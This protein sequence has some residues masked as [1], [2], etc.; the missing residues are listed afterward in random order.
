[1]PSLFRRPKSRFL[2]VP[3]WLT[4]SRF[5]CA[6]RHV[7]SALHGTTVWA[8]GVLSYELVHGRPPF[9]GGTREETER[10]I[11]EQEVAVAPQVGT[12]LCRH[13]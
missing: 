6:A 11:A 9:L 13:L 5:P 10:L 12:A 2:T 4:F 8:L 3:W 7:P 1:M